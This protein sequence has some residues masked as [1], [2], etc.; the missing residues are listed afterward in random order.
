MPEDLAENL[1]LNF[2]ELFLYLSFY[3]SSII[4]LQ[5]LFL[6]LLWFLS[7]WFH[8]FVCSTWVLVCSPACSSLTF[9][10]I[11]GAF[12]SQLFCVLGCSGTYPSTF[13][14]LPSN[15]FLILA[16]LSFAS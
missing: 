6:A 12:R 15:L 4:C 16:Y 7:Y 1:F 2:C 11:L 9:Q 14:F 8:F 5:D 10:S 3:Y 13:S